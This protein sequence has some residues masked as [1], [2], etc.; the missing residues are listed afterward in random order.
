MVLA[1]L[2]TAMCRFIFAQRQ[3]VN[4][5]TYLEIRKTSR[6]QKD[7]HPTSHEFTDNAKEV[8]R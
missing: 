3:L 8:E 1:D 2:L 4:G 7:V 6:K 5:N